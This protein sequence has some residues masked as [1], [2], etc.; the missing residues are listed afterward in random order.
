M[1]AYKLDLQDLT[2]ISKWQSVVALVAYYPIHIHSLLT[3]HSKTLHV[4]CSLRITSAMV[5]CGSNCASCGC[6]RT[7]QMLQIGGRLWVV[8]V[9]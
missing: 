5:N 8:L 7:L 4:V 2:C 9:S 6:F 3:R 1:P